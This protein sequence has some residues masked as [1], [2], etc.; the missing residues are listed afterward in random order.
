MRLQGS[1]GQ[2]R[3]DSLYT[4]DVTLGGSAA[5]IV[6]GKSMSRSSLILQN[7]G[8]H[9]MAVEIG[10]ARATATLTGSVVT[11][12]SIT[13]AGWNYTKPPLVRFLGGGYAGGS[14]NDPAY[15][16]AYLGLNQ[17]NGA[18]P[19]DPAQGIAVMTGSAGNLSVA[20]ITIING[21]ANYAIAPYVMLIS[22]DL[23]PYGC[24]LPAVGSAGIQLPASQAVPIAFNGTICPTDAISVIGTSGDILLCR[25][26]D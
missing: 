8:T 21:G 15:N 24:A 11:S 23:D 1:G 9:V 2:Q 6:L 22:S 20:S 14:S 13:N 25:W 18:T 10:G 16:S 12:C 19:S 26:L 3:Q 4:A 17:P 7:L 5:Q